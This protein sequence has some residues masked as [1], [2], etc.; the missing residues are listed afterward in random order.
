MH[1]SLRDFF[2][3]GGCLVVFGL[4]VTLN[5]QLDNML[6][7]VPTILPNSLTYYF[8]I[9][10]AIIGLTVAGLA[11]IAFF[12]LATVNKYLLAGY[13]FGIVVMLIVEC[14]AVIFLAVTPKYIGIHVDSET[15][16]DNW[17]RNYGV[18]GREHYTASVDMIQ[19]MWDCCGVENGLEYSTSWWSLRE[20]A[21]P[22]LVVPLSCCIQH[23]SKSYLDPQPVNVTLCQDKN[24]EAHTFG[25]H[26]EGCFMPLKTWLSQEV[27]LIL[28][29]VAIIIL[30]QLLLLFLSIIGCL[31]L[32]KKL[33]K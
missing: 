9:S 22:G 14:T 13:I 2:V 32:N 16:V 10:S 23:S 27:M 17:Q 19:T 20:L 33:S 21:S 15:L 3:G 25:R 12:A 11:L 31:K 6:R 5:D 4:S 26:T 7:L 29:A 28:Y 8:S 30:Y 24:P 1:S 18:P